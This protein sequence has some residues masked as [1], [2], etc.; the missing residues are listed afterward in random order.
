MQTK[1]PAH[2]SKYPPSRSQLPDF[3]AATSRYRA[4]FAQTEA[5]LLSIQ[6]LR[7]EV[8]NLELGEGL[9]S[10]HLNQLDRDRFDLQCHHLLVEAIDGDAIVG[11]YRM[12]TSEMASEGA[13]F[14]SMGEFDFSGW[15]RT[16]IDASVE[17]GRAC[18]AREHRHRQ[19]L[20]LLWKGLA[21]YAISNGK[22]YVFGCCSLSTQD[23]ALAGRAWEYLRQHGHHDASLPLPAVDRCRCAYE[24]ADLRGWEDVKLPQLF[25]TYL[26]YGAKIVGE[27]AIDREFQT[28]DYLA[29][30]DLRALDTAAMLRQLEFDPQG[31]R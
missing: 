3:R 13:G 14:Y 7:Y 15:P 26:R 19:V 10:S 17:T 24:E 31:G 1:R 2:S 25:R 23:E 4:R 9:A 28:V 16:L 8:F 22:R 5:D 11:T 6:R 12:Q 29:L 20:L 27:P 21:S 30:V 18:I